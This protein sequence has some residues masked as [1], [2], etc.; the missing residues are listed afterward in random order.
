M[1]MNIILVDV[2]VVGQGEVLA[3]RLA[4]EAARPFFEEAVGSETRDAVAVLDFRWVRLTTSSY[5]LGAFEWLWTSKVAREND[6]FPILANA[7][8]ET[9]DEIELALN[10]RGFKA[11]FAQ[12]DAGGLSDVTP[13]NLD[14]EA[15]ETYE[16][17][18]SLGEA[19][20]TD[21]FRIDPKIQPTGWSNRLALLYEH[22]LL[23]RRKNGRQLIYALSWR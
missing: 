22:R 2:G 18:S 20:A 4:G 10:A 12:F 19:T 7:N 11:L 16:K 3:G 21:I 1:V 9:R 13:F 15:A 14:R 5:F 8:Q 17:V 23:R 6:I